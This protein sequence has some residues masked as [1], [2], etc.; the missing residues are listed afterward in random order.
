MTTFVYEGTEVRKTGRHAVKS[1]PTLRRA[2]EITLFEITP[3]GDED[4]WKKWV[5]EDSLYEVVQ[6]ESDK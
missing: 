5:T 4:G 2:K 6:Q 3:V 1:V